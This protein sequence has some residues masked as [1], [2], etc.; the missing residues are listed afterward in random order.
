MDMVQDLQMK[1]QG[2]DISIVQQAQA[3]QT[4]RYSALLLTDLRLWVK[5]V[6][7]QKTWILNDTQGTGCNLIFFKSLSLETERYTI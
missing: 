4:D 5:T 1:Q 7:R 6:S 2:R 3:E